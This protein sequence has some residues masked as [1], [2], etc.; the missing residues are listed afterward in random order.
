MR[1]SCGY[2][3]L[4]N[5]SNTCYLNSLFTQLYMNPALRRFIFNTNIAEPQASQRLLFEVQKCFANLQNSW[6]RCYDPTDLAAS[7]RTYDNESIDVCIQM[8]VDEFY[9]L[10][11]DRLEGQILDA[12]DKQFFRKIYGG[13][14]VQQVKS[15]ECEHISEREEPFSAIQCDIK[16]KSTL[17]ESLR[18]Y[19]EGEIMEGDNKYSCT[20]CNKHVNAVKRTCLKDI[21]NNLIFH[22][23]RFDFDLRTMQRSKINDHFQFPNT[24]DMM[25]YGIDHLSDTEKE[26]PSDMFELVG[27]LV[28][29]GT[30][31]TGHYYSYIRERPSDSSSEP[32][33][34]IEF[35]DADV[36]YFDAEQM[37]GY[38]FGGPENF[39]LPNDPSGYTFQKVYSA[40]MLFYQRSSSLAEEQ[41]TQQG[42]GLTA[43]IKFD[44][45]DELSEE[46]VQNN[47]SLL[48]RYCLFDTNHTKFVTKL[49]EIGTMFNLGECSLDHEV[50]V[51]AINLALNTM[52]QV[53][54]RTKGAPEFESM[55]NILQ[56]VATRCLTCV[57]IILRWTSENEDA[58]KNCIL[59]CPEPAVRNE[60]VNFTVEAMRRMKYGSPEDYGIR[61]ATNENGEDV[62][63][64]R[65]QDMCTNLICY[66]DKLYLHTRSWE[67]YFNL[68]CHLASFGAA[69]R[70][71]LLDYVFLEK[72][73]ELVMLDQLDR[74][75]RIEYDLL[76][77]AL[78]RKK[79]KET[80]YSQ[81]IQFISIML[82]SV[83]L[84][85][86]SSTNFSGKERQEIGYAPIYPPTRTEARYM[87]YTLRGDEVN[88]QIYW[89]TR[90]LD[91][92]HNPTATSDIVRQM[93]Q[94]EPQAGLLDEWPKTLMA[95][96]AHNPA[97]AA[98]PYL[99]AS[100]VF[101]EH[102]PEL[103]LI[104]HLTLKTA[105]DVDT[106]GNSGG[107][108]HLSFFRDL[109]KLK[110]SRVDVMLIQQQVINLIPLWA[111]ALLGYAD[112]IVRSETKE[113]VEY[114]LFQH[115]PDSSVFEQL[116]NNSIKFLESK[117][118]NIQTKIDAPS[119]D[120]LIRGIEE[121]ISYLNRDVTEEGIETVLSQRFERLKLQ[122][123]KR[124][125]EETETSGESDIETDSLIEEELG[126]I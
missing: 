72:S 81:I 20:Q 10:L 30:A 13:Q 83:D 22:L 64:G 65:F 62:G 123:Q 25:P 23:K 57:D 47:D 69:E 102:C 118:V 79:K 14:L 63:D 48:R 27:V 21:P 90:M 95:K 105:E 66:W 39:C 44:V 114:L 100:V 121:C 61:Y 125:V 78:L 53:V 29:S 49:L 12:D 110:T 59:R 85:Q 37:S 91:L 86:I 2:V 46:I 93:T 112:K 70:K 56:N 33:N 51:K 40:Y 87:R 35:N 80:S 24:I 77:K 36:T 104:E 99:V 6:E 115:Q 94:A 34:W 120:V 52:E 71:I 45:R 106:I 3:G 16:G 117:Y 15:K 96:I 60:F 88:G 126:L 17:Q 103:P 82:C 76:I 55:L 89:I 122:L 43:P 11:C 84:E 111:P 5:L 7:I 119:I 19:V 18:A 58:F 75:K 68:L 109:T 50:E 4:R 73:L 38:C 113:L 1:S 101:C 32:P 98:G 31:E 9:N 124:V 107:P 116:A 97:S 54:I 108:E 28:H 42:L 8:D 41:V 74:A 92:N 67:A 26:A